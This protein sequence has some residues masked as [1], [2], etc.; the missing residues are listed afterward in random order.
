M[1]KS[2]L[3]IARRS[4]D[5]AVRAT[6]KTQKTCPSCRG[7][8]GKGKSLL[9]SAIIKTIEEEQSRTQPGGIKMPG[10][11]SPASKSKVVRAIRGRVSTPGKQSAKVRH[12]ELMGILLTAGH[13]CWRLA[14]SMGESYKLAGQFYKGEQRRQLPFWKNRW[15]VCCLDK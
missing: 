12:G 3:P 8:L 10:L 9:S 7:P 5:I 4:L 13:L 6:H 11:S 2:T 14:M 15:M 1:T